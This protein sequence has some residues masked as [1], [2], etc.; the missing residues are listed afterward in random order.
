MVGLHGSPL[1]KPYS[2]ASA[3]W[4]VTNTGVLQ[5]LAQV[6]DSSALDPHLELAAPGALID[7]DGPFGTFAVPAAAEHKPLLFIAGG[8]GIAP[9][10]SLL[11]DRLSRP[12]VPAIALIYSARSP[13]EF[14][15]RTE[16]DAMVQAGRITA[17]FTATRAEMGSWEGRRGR[18]EEDLL[19]LALPS[20]DA[21]CLICGPPQLVEDARGLL[22]RLGMG[23]ANI[24]TD[25]Y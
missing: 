18:I 25:Q 21:Y 6:D 12:L 5:L 20:S 9:L 13:D 16:L 2:I 23:E 19:R 24:L 17:H 7:L 8:T 1:R 10:R 11:M 3:P 15:Y 4:E 22:R 14:A